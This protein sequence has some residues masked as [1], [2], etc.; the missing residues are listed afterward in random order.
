MNIIKKKN[1][2]AGQQRKISIIILKLKTASTWLDKIDTFRG[3]FLNEIQPNKRLLGGK[4]VQWAIRFVSSILI[5]SLPDPSV[6]KEFVANARGYLLHVGGG[7]Q[8]IK[9]LNRMLLFFSIVSPDNRKKRMIKKLNGIDANATR[10][11]FQMSN[12]LK[13]FQQSVLD[14]DT[15]TNDQ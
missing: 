7:L 5:E 10:F 3:E 2:N 6:L 8:N 9:L 14:L 11:D 13:V 4:Q 12:A 15:L 1:Q